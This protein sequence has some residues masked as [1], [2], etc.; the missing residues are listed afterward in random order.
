MKLFPVKIEGDSYNL[1]IAKSEYDYQIS[2]S[3]TTIK[4]ER[5]IF[6]N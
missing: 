6:K 4:G 3:P 2:L 5:I 1:D